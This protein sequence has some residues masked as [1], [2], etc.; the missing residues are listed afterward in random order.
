[1]AVLSSMLFWQPCDDEDNVQAQIAAFHEAGFEGTDEYTP[2]GADNSEIQQGLPQVRLLRTLTAE[3]ASADSSNSQWTADPAEEIAA[4]VKIDRW[5]SGAQVSHDRHRPA[6]L[7]SAAVDGLPGLASHAQWCSRQR[8]GAPQRW[9]DGDPHSGGN[10]S[11]RC[12]IGASPR[13]QWAGIGLSLAALA[14]TLVLWLKGRRRL[15]G[16]GFR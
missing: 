13:D 10:E 11:H 12:A 4:D 1:M 9:T 6:C 5:N 7:R 8:A 15:D 3:E 2:Q 14:I 16:S